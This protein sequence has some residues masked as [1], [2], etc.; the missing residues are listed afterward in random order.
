MI[1][2]LRSISE[3]MT[4]ITRKQIITNYHILVTQYLKKIRKP[5]NDIWSV[6]KYNMGNTFLE[7]PHTKCGG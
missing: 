2:K 4:S 7:K 6:E 1:R 5:D 3:F